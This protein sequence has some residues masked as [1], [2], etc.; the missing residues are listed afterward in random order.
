MSRSETDIP[1]ADLSVTS[2]SDVADASPSGRVIMI[3]RS[4]K[5]SLDS[6]DLPGQPSHPNIDKVP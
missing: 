1:R 3:H 4:R 2:E 6:R 5:D